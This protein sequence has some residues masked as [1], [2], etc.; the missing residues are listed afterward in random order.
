MS[1]GIHEHLVTSVQ[2]LLELDYPSHQLPETAIKVFSL[3]SPQQQALIK[4]SYREQMTA[5]VCVRRFGLTRW[6]D[7]TFADIFASHVIWTHVAFVYPDNS[8]AP[9]YVLI[10]TST[11][12]HNLYISDKHLIQYLTV[13]LRTHPFE[14]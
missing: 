2:K 13:P 1:L 7:E 14:A 12:W 10:G 9:K 6:A 5:A 8:E 4:R 11:G 3:N